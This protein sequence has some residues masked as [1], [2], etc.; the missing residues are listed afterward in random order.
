MFPEVNT[1]APAVM[2]VF[3]TVLTE[4]PLS[5]V[6]LARRLGL[7]SAAITKAAR[8]LIDLGY[9]QEMAATERT[10]TGAGRAPRAARAGGR[11]EPVAAGRSGTRHVPGH[12]LT[13]R[14]VRSERPSADLGKH[15]R[16]LGLI[17]SFVK[18]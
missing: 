2:A 16:N 4:G 14:G 5:R 3:T 11:V 18:Y 13:S 17:F 10:G 12:Q 6:G 7:S 8:P 15:R 9:L 1:V